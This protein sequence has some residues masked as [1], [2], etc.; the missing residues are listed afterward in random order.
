[1]SAWEDVPTVA[2][3]AEWSEEDSEE[4][5]VDAF[6]ELAGYFAESKRH[7]QNGYMAR[8][9]GS[10]WCLEL[11]HK[12]NE[13]GDWPEDDGIHESGW[14]GTLLCK[15]TQYDTCCTECEGECDY[16]WPPPIWAMSGVRGAKASA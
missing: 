5:L 2:E 3:M 15:A 12:P 14:E 6:D 4:W 10:K 1:M 8:E 7:D 11:G 13:Y 16:E 9:A